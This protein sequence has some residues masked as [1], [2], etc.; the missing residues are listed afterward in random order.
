MRLLLVAAVAAAAPARHRHTHALIADGVDHERERHT[1]TGHGYE[2]ERR[3]HTGHSHDGPPARHHH[4]HTH[5]PIS[6]GADHERERRGH[7]GHAYNGELVATWHTSTVS[8]NLHS[9]ELYIP[10]LVKQTCD[11]GKPC[12]TIEDARLGT[13]VHITIE[14]IVALYYGRHGESVWNKMMQKIKMGMDNALKFADSP[15]YAAGIMDA[16]TL[17]RAIVLQA[18]KY[19]DILG[20]LQVNR[21]TENPHEAGSAQ[22]KWRNFSNK[23]LAA[24]RQIFVPREWLAKELSALRVASRSSSSSRWDESAEEPSAC[25]RAAPRAP[26]G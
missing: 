25:R 2:R 1:H 14:G 9:N 10:E 23:A 20:I 26:R 6:E 21:E 22:Y 24:A 13:D 3:G 16:V 7:N 18:G 12:V 17:A 15:L 8:A 11:G 19:D 4:Q 5:A